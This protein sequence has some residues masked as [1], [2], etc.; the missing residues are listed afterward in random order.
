[1][2]PKTTLARDYGVTSSLTNITQCHIFVY[3]WPDQLRDR[4]SN[5]NESFDL[6]VDIK[7]YSFEPLAKK[8]HRQ[9]Q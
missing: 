3:K 5:S 1:M 8:G 6:L 4:M 2:F 7:S 9:Y